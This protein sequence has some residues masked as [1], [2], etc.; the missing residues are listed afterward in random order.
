MRSVIYEHS[1]HGT[2]INETQKPVPLVLP[3][4]EYSCP[5][6]GIVVD[7]F[8]G[9]GTTLIAARDLGRRAIGIEL[10]ED[11]CEKAAEEAIANHP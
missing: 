2:A 8:A 11:Q 6:G 9:S 3:L 4:I 1:C 5:P 10:R 7:P